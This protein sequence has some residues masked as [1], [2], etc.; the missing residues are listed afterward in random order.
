MYEGLLP[1]EHIPV[2]LVV[3]SQLSSWS[4]DVLFV[5]VEGLE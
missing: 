2:V 3:E 5:L 4:T 1:S